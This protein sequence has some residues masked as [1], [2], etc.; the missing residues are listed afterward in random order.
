MNKIFDDFK[1]IVIGP[2]QSTTIPANS[3]VKFT[4]TYDR[5]KYYALSNVSVP[6]HYAINFI[7]II[8]YASGPLVTNNTSESRAPYVSAFLFRK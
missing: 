7:S 5:T 6:D 2:D 1:C 8:Y 3:S 4:F